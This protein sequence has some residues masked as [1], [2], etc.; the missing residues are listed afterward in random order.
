[1]LEK[2]QIEKIVSQFSLP[3]W[4]DVI[5][6]LMKDSEFEAL[7]TG[8]EQNILNKA[9]N[10]PGTIRQYKDRF[11]DIIAKYYSWE[12]YNS[13]SKL[14]PLRKKIT[15]LTA[16]IEGSQ[17]D[18][19]D[20]KRNVELTSGAT[21]LAAYSETF[22]TSA[23]RHRDR[24]NNIQ[25]WYFGSV[26]LLLAVVGLVFFFSI[27]DYEILKS[28]LAEDVLF[29]FSL[30]VYIFKLILVL[31]FFQIVQFFRKSY[32]AEKHLEEIYRHR[33]DV[34]Q[35]LH[36]VYN[37]IDDKEEKDKLLAAA[38]MFAYERGE[39]GY[40]TTKEGAGSDSGYLEGLLSKVTR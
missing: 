3:D 34:L 6:E 28:Y 15:D 1:M 5:Y 12:L 36:A 23:D 22:S 16:Q 38:A 26:A 13:K 10:D 11:A 40:I 14:A 32:N 18:L 8:E 2:S 30:G 25:K 33:S 35:S 27:A 17:T 9:K 7:L 39:T 19:N 21:A 4:T 20:L 24:A 29:E 31:F 37:A